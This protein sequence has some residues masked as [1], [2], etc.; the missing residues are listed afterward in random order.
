[1]LLWL[2]ENLESITISTSY[3]SSL[4]KAGIKI[5]DFHEE[6]DIV[7]KTYKI[8]LLFLK[9]EDA[10]HL[11]PNSASQPKAGKPLLVIQG[12]Q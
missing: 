2:R 8:I 9:W 12:L 11:P 1:M 6:L 7:S 5:T 3:P 4:W 10:L